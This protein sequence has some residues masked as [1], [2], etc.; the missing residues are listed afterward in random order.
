MLD[1]MGQTG[2]SDYDIRYEV[3]VVQ[4]R[5]QM[6]S[7]RRLHPFTVKIRS[8]SHYVCM[9]EVYHLDE[10]LYGYRG[11]GVRSCIVSCMYVLPYVKCSQ[12]YFKRFERERDATATPSSLV[13]TGCGILIG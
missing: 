11:A 6:S 1:Q 5:G 7:K 9:D 2:P 3:K 4:Y 8:N 12:W 13:R 10:V